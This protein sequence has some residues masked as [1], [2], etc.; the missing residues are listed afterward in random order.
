MRSSAL[1]RA[2]HR[3]AAQ[4][5]V[6]PDYIS[7]TGGLDQVTAPLSRRPGVARTA[8]NY[9]AEQ[10]GGYRRIAGYER[11]DGRSSPSGAQYSI[12]TATITGAPV[13]GNTLT[14]ASSG[15]T[16]VIIALP[17]GSFVLTKVVGTYT[18]GE[19]LTIGGVVATAVGTQIANGAATALLHAQYLNLAADD[20]RADIAAVTGSGSILG[21]FTF[22]D[23]KYAFRNNVGGTAAALY[24]STT[25]GWSL[26]AFEFEVAFTVGSGD[27]DDGDTLTQGGVTATVRRVVIR[28]GT[29]AGGTAAGILV[30]SVTAGG[31]FGAGAA[32][33][34]GAG[35]LTLSGIQTAITLLP[36]GRFETIQENFGTAKR[37]YGVDRVNR[38]F[39]FDGTYFVP[40]PSGMTTDKPTHI[41]AHKKHLFLS[42]ATSAQHSGPGT[43][44]AMVPVLGAAEIAMGDTI[45]G[46]MT[47]PGSA[48][49]GA[50]AIFTRNRL[51]ILYG[52]SS[53]DWNL[54]PYRDEIG[55]YAHT[56]QD[57]GYALFVDDRGIT[58]IQTTQAFGNFA[59]AAISNQI[60]NLMNAYRP[61][62][63]SSC[64]SRDRSQYRLFFS[65][66]VAFYVTVVGRSV[67]GIMPMLFPDIVRCCWSTEL[68]DGSEAI[69]FGSDDG[70]VYQMEKG[71]SFDGDA[72]EG[73][74]EL[75]Y[76]FGKSPRT[77]KRFRDALL[78]LS[79]TGY[80]EFN[81]G[82]S[83]GYGTTDLAQPPT[84]SVVTSF[85]PVFWDSF[86]WDAFF[87]D[88]TT[89]S[90]NIL[91]MDGEAENY[92]LAIRGE[93][94]YL[95]PF[96][97]TGA[98]V[99]YTPRRR[100]R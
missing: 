39:E 40:I 14:G 34:T 60:K 100:M 7:F 55:A 47:M 38:A 10:L 64:V 82:Y 44:F 17:G 2:V 63:L 28:T 37:V 52:T 59:H 91:K 99:Q 56:I 26:V 46:F 43:P 21:G 78:E 6:I 11:F 54:V 13:A 71:T 41:R 80:T 81:F 66:R 48:D 36:S 31:N 50:L 57:V 98:V 90:P 96:T 49:S 97:I 87:W 61:L 45:T 75:A 1:V 70:W 94:D 22:N 20:Y 68:N 42:F 95:Q 88:G 8:Q 29:L 83:L 19:N 85:S 65:N 3:S 62:A 51:S 35:T 79:G 76:N 27:V 69:F 32:T 18:N 89:L 30:I 16:G 23:V 12:L 53:V 24:K 9:E 93:S 92:S 33:T 58:D 67:V 15:A 77:V 4:T 86:V 72:I 5:T 25:G 74:L 84:E 73:I